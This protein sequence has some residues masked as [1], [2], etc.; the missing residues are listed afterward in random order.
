MLVDK[1]KR[2][3]AQGSSDMDQLREHLKRSESVLLQSAQSALEKSKR[4]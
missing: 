1:I 4:S 3:Q 2:A